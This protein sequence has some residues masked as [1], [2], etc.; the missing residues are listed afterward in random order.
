MS[1]DPRFSLALALA[2]LAWSAA[3]AS[4]QPIFDL[5]AVTEIRAQYLADLDSVRTKVVALANAIPE[6]SFQ[7]RPGHPDRERSADARRLRVVLLRA[8]SGGR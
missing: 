1:F 7:W 3:P 8:A 6:A 2:A 5:K 4:A